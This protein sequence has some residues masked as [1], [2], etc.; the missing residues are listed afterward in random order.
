MPSDS[1]PAESVK[2]SITYRG[3]HHLVSVP[4]SSP[5]SAL[6]AQLEALTSVP[7]SLQKL[8]YKGKKTTSKS[9]DED[10]VTVGEAGLRDGMKVQLLGAT[11]EE[12]GGMKAAE[13]AQRKRENI[14]R[15][16]T[17][18]PQV[19]VRSTGPPPG[20]APTQYRFH[21]LVPLPHLPNPPAALALLTKLSEDPAIRHVMQK[22]HFSVDVLTELAPH[23]HPDL[24]G[25][26]VTDGQ[27]IT[28]KLRLRTNGYDGFRMYKEVRR[29]LCHELAHN[30]WHDHSEDFKELNSKLNRE[31]VEFELAAAKGT[32]YLSDLGIEAYD[33]S[34]SSSKA[35]SG[36]HVLGG[37]SLVT[38]SQNESPEERRQRILNATMSRLQKQDDELEHQCGSGRVN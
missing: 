12:L 37:G 28:I 26:N 20:Q 5:L 33:P 29:V 24:L 31:V 30:V 15:E 8:L 9:Q 21:R 25:L 22:H 6:Q 27:S 10:V 2:L 23:E 35:F 1:T 36:V 16:R 38:G 4:P 32:H 7:P 14:L 13:S 34:E 3:T 19:K 11:L 18:K 17:T